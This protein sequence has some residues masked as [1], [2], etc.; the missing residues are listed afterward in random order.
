MG[1]DRA[2]KVIVSAYAVTLGST[3]AANSVFN[4]QNSPLYDLLQMLLPPG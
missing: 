4:L 1:F 2:L 3:I